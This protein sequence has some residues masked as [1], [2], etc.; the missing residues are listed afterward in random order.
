MLKISWVHEWVTSNWI[1]TTVNHESFRPEERFPMM[2]TFKVLLCGAVLSRVDAGQ[3]QL[4]RHIHY[5]QN[6]G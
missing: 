2:S 1:S 3:E 5:S 4:G 6:D